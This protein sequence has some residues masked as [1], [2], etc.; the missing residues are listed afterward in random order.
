MARARPPANM[1]RSSHSRRP[2]G[3]AKHRIVDPRR[4]T[5]AGGWALTLRRAL[6][7]LQVAVDFVVQADCRNGQGDV[8]R[9]C[10]GVD[11]AGGFSCAQG[12]LSFLLRGYPDSLEELAHA[13]FERF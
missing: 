11:L 1:S 12:F 2:S 13:R 3:T 6:L 8:C 7:Q 9:D 5:P 4:T 10:A